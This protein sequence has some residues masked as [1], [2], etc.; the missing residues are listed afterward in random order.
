MA[1]VRSRIVAS[2][3]THGAAVTHPSPLLSLLLCQMA[4]VA[5]AASEG[6]VCEFLL[7]LLQECAGALHRVTELGGK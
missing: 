5:I 6:D 2:L 7:G 3:L 4:G 1:G